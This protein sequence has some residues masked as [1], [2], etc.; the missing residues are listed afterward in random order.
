MHW[1]FASVLVV[2]VAVS[3][4]SLGTQA[5]QLRSQEAPA[6]AALMN[7]KKWNLPH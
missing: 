5:L 4:V 1:L 6:G 3:L 2:A 7:M